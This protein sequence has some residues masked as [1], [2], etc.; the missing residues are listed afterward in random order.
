MSRIDLTELNCEVYIRTG[1]CQE[2]SHFERISLDNLRS[3]TRPNRRESTSDRMY[4]MQGSG[5]HEI[6]VGSQLCKAV[7]EIP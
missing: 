7:Y 3:R 5:E 1:C 4:T 6:F 2:N